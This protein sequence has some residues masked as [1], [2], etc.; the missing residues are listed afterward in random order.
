M[1]SSAQ[2][3][4]LE[5]A[6]SIY[7][8][9]L[10]AVAH[11]LTARGIT[12]ETAV[13]YR[14]GYVAKPVRGDDEMAGR[15]SIP[16]LTTG[17]VVDIRYRAVGNTE[18]PKYLSRSGSKARLFS[19]TSLLKPS[20]SIVLTEGEIDC[21]TLNQIGVPAVGFPGA[22]AWQSHWRLMFS[23]YDEIVVVCDGDQAGR[24]FGK[25]LAEKL[26]GV[27]VTHLPDGTDINDLY[28]REGADALKEKVG[29]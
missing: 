22:N 17:G 7:E 4:V 28:V 16:Y 23:D 12:K 19:V 6:T 13:R 27:I 11:Y 15:L 18:G 21:I 5:E 3:R 2:L 8:Q 9:N 20:K 24:D 26:D 29:L 25:R 10:D 14:L 1:L